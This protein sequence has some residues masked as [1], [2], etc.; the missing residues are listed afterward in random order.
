M[1]A[2]YR[3]HLKVYYSQIC[4]F[5]NYLRKHLKSYQV[6]SIDLHGQLQFPVILTIDKCTISKIYKPL[7]FHTANENIQAFYINPISLGRKY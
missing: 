2:N 5:I 6:Q 4:K 1:L 7:T 3:H